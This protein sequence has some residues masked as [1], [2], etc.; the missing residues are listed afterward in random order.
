MKYLINGQ[1][2][3]VGDVVEI[4]VISDDSGNA[5]DLYGVEP[6]LNVWVEIVYL[7]AVTGDVIFCPELLMA[8]VQVGKKKIPLSPYLRSHHIE[9]NFIR[10]NEDDIENFCE[11]GPHDWGKFGPEYVTNYLKIIKKK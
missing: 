11:E 5:T 2:V 3:T 4:I 9:Q 6:H 10:I 7:E 8:V 1:E